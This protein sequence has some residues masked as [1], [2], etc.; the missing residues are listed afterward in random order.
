VTTPPPLTLSFDLED[1]RPSPDA[2]PERYTASTERLLAWLEERKIRATVFVVGELAAAEPALVRSIADAGH[3][4]G[5]HH[6]QHV[7]L[8]RQTPDEMRDGARRGKAVLEDLLGVPVLGFRAPTASLVRQTVRAADILA[9]EGYAYSSSVI[10]ARNPLF[11][12]DGL[13]SHPFRWPSGLAE[14]PMHVGGIGPVKL[15]YVSGTYLRILPW[16]VIRALTANQPWAAGASTYFHPYDIDP[17]EP[18][19]WLDDAGWMSPLLWL[20]RKHMLDRLDKLFADGG[21]PPLGEL[22]HLADAHVLAELP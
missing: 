22:L 14:F 4:I 21:A 7:Q 19:W 15:P 18:F 2:W 1:H 12:F 17:D 9:E 20:N 8:M 11:G 16:P 13:P 5:L 3:E 6:W 10:P